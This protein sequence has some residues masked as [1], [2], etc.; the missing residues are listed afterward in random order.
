MFTFAI[1]HETTL[2]LSSSVESSLSMSA[3]CFPLHTRTL[4][5]QDVLPGESSPPLNRRRSQKARTSTSAP[6]AIIAR[7]SRLSSRK[8]VKMFLMF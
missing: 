8:S 6:S 7:R 2:T 1:L 5:A 3:T 4:S